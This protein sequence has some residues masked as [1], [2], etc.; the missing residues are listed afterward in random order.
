MQKWVMFA[1]QLVMLQ[2][3]S[4]RKVTKFS[5]YIELPLQDIVDTSKTSLN[6]PH[7]FHILSTVSAS[8]LGTKIQQHRFS[9][10]FWKNYPHLYWTHNNVRS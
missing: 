9:E 2:F 4:R 1:Q 5:V 10:L 6:L 3:P 7:F 8:T